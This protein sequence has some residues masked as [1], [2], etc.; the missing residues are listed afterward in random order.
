M[1]HHLRLVSFCLAMG[2]MLGAL[3]AVSAAEDAPTVLVEEDF[4][5]GAERWE[6]TDANAWEIG[7]D[8]GVAIYRLARQSEYEPPHRSPLNIS[9]LKDAE[10]DS[11]QF[12]VDLRSTTEDYGHRSMCL[13]F[14]YV[15]P[16]H[17]YYVHLGKEMDDHANQIFIVNDAPRIK[18]STK[19]T[20]GTPWDDA[21]H[22][23][24]ITRD[25]TSGE[26]AVY[27]DDME[28]PV[29]TA[30]DKT[31]ARGRIGLGAFD[32]EG[33]FKNVVVRAK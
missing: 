33:D 29:M 1:P 23:V 6:P 3:L 13:F 16:A 20:D 26:I 11:F 7:E 28:E 31:F 32:D 21:W 27:W 5:E 15:D 4:S 18:I 17:F 8:D 24:R 10:F 14:G 30:T 25:A 22:H 9:L 19:T 2:Y 12:D